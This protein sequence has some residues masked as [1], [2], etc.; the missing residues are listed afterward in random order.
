MARVAPQIKVEVGQCYVLWTFVVI[1]QHTYACSICICSGFCIH[2]GVSY[3]CRHTDLCMCA[4]DPNA[5]M[6]EP[7]CLSQCNVLPVS[8]LSIVNPLVGFVT[9]R[10]VP[11]LEGVLRTAGPISVFARAG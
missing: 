2:V 10:P 7:V 3:T 11:V 5:V 6:E 8:F 4:T 1:R 9:C